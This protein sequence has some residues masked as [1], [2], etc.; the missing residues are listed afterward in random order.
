MTAMNRQE[1][2]QMK[3]KGVERKM[4]LETQERKKGKGLSTKVIFILLILI[5]SIAI[6]NIAS[7]V[8]LNKNV[9]SNIRE[10]ELGN[11]ANVVL[12]NM[13]NYDLGEY[14][15]TNG[16]LL[17]GSYNLSNTE[18]MTRISEKIGLKM[19][20]YWDNI[21]VI[22]NF[23]DENQNSMINYEM[24]DVVYQ[25]VCGQGE[26][27]FV[28]SET[29]SGQTYS[30]I[31]IPIRQSSGEV[32]GALQVGMGLQ[33]VN[34]DIEAIFYKNMII[35]AI[36][37]VLV[38]VIGLVIALNLCKRLKAISSFVGTVAQGNIQEGIDERYLRGSDEIAEIA[39]NA[40]LLEQKLQ[41]I[42]IKINGLV[43][44]LHGNATDILEISDKA[45][46]SMEDVKTAVTEIADG[47]MSQAEYTQNANEDVISIGEDI[48]QTNDVVIDLN[49]TASDMVTSNEQVDQSIDSLTEHSKLTNQNIEKISEN[50][51]KTDESVKRIAEA[52]SAITS[53]ATQTNLLA[54]NA[55]IESA[56]AG[57]AGKGFAVVADQ[58]RQLAEQSKN[59]AGK[60]EDII[61]ELSEN[62]KNS[63]QAIEDVKE[64]TIKQNTIM[65]DVNERVA[66]STK[67]LNS[68]TEK[69]KVVLE[70]TSKLENAKNNIHRV[71]EEL[72]A[73]SEENAAS[74]EETTASTEEVLGSMKDVDNLVMKMK[75][76]AEDLADSVEFFRFERKN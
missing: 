33:Q 1:K 32:V 47:A 64:S 31:Y 23:M 65:D 41:S 42:I 55:S 58:I 20:I 40:N 56:R 3:E 8:A 22:S 7:V 45:T 39:V 9:V 60:I 15:F 18:W 29:I 51:M 53:I 19:S 71:L 13:N 54:L 68:M 50:T 44:E 76:V 63:V 11:L 66:S 10:E 30:I 73:I 74:T 25:T 62:S 4:M 49:K 12:E 52:L 36:I 16:Q 5:L 43:D 70:Y 14:S 6:A 46:N 72:S 69:I 48:N 2:V 28:L 24:N 21:S 59:A 35:L 67:L 61:G 38:M 75:N 57:E 34:S 26:N 27:Y 37:T 17:K